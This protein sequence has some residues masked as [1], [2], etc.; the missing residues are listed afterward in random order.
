GRFPTP[1]ATGG[2]DVDKQVVLDLT[3]ESRGNAN[4]VGTADF[5]TV[6]LAEKMRLADTYPNSLTSTVPGPVKLPM[7]LPSDLLAIKA[8]ILTCHAVGRA[9][10][11][12]RIRDTLTLGEMWV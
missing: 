10:R 2:P 12:V 5:T 9:P 3:A 7:V 1:F 8:A 6:R 11:V 4:G